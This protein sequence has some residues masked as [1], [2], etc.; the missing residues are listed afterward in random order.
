LSWDSSICSYNRQ[1]D[2]FL[3]F[4]KKPVIHYERS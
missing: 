2:L 1:I 4:L 3:L